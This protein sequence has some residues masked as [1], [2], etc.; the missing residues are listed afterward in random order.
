MGVLENAVAGAGTGAA[1]G[2]AVA[3]G[4]GTAIGGAIGFLAPIIADLIGRA[5][6]SGDKEEA[7]RLLQSAVDQFGPDI[8]K[9][10]SIADL[11]PHLGPSAVESVYADPAAVAAQREALQELQRASRPDNLEFRA[12]ANEAEQFANQQAGAQQGAI[13]QQMQ[14]RGMGGSGVD[15]ALQQQA[16]QDAANRAA[17]HGFGAAMEGRRQALRSLQDYGNLAG[18]MRGQSFGEGV[19]RGRARDEV[20][21]LNE[22]GRVAGQQQAFDNQMGISRARA[23]LLGQQSDVA[24]GESR[25]TQ[26]QWG[27]YGVGAGQAAASIGGAYDAY[28]AEQQRKED[29]TRRAAQGGR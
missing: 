27:N 13:R 2:T 22:A 15:F 7:E 29:E 8:L 24:R 20:A 10:P 9:A 11:T 23:D 26:Q 16:G 5:L 6:G 12:A 18:T 25:T 14:A 21:R 4:I 3:P 17:S 19:T 1:A 28:K